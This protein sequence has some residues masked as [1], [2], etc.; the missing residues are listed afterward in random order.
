MQDD[1]QCRRQTHACTVK[2]HGQPAEYLV[3]R[4]TCKHTAA[5]CPTSHPSMVPAGTAKRSRLCCHGCSCG[6]PCVLLQPVLTSVRAAKASPS[7]RPGGRCSM[8]SAVFQLMLRLSI[9]SSLCLQAS[10]HTRSWYLCTHITR[11]NVMGDCWHRGR[12]HKQTSTA[13]SGCSRVASMFS[14]CIASA[15]AQ[16]APWQN[17]ASA[18]THSCLVLPHQHLLLVLCIGMQST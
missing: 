5:T 13:P 12:V 15:W 9:V 3:S 11:D 8:A 1:T 17:I 4:S 7:C 2:Q 14:A 18:H 10:T 6:Q 16:T